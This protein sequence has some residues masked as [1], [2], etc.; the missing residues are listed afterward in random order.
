MSLNRI[1][2]PRW[3]R[4]AIPILIALLIVI[5]ALLLLP[6]AQS[7]PPMREAA[8]ELRPAD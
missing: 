5:L 7:A 1:D 6:D 4:V 2:W 3:A 8:N